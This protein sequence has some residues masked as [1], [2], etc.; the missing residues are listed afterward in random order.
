MNSLCFH[1]SEPLGTSRLVAHINGRDEPVCCAGC[2]AVAELI[3]GAGL[4]QY[5]E[6]RSGRPQ[7]PDETVLADDAWSAYAQAGIAAG[8]VSSQGDLD[9]AT[10]GV[11][12]IRCAAC[13]WL[14]DR[15]VRQ[16]DGVVRVSVNAA[17]ARVHVEWRRDTLNLADIMRSIARAGYRPFPPGDSR[18]VERQQQER[19]ATL[20]R[21][22][23]SGFGMMQVMMF[24]FAAYSAQ[25]RGEAIDPTL[26]EFFRMVSM[27]VAAPVMCYA[28]LPIFANAWRALV[29]R[30]LGMDVPVALALLLAFGASVW[31]TFHGNT[32]EVYF[33]S[34]TMFIFFVTLGR[35]IQMSVRHR[36]TS[37]TDALA[38]QMPAIAHRLEND[39][40]FDVP[41]ATL[42]PGDAVLVRRGEVLPA[43]GELLDAHAQVDESLLTGESAAVHRQQ[44]QLLSGGSVNV[45][46]PLRMAVTTLAHAST[47]A[48]VV[49]LMQRAQAQRPRITAAADAASVRFLWAVVSAAAITALTW[50]FVNPARAFDAT[51]AVLVVACPCAFAIAIPAAV[52]AAI[53]NLARRGVLVTHPDALERL[54]DV[55]RAVFDKTGTLTRGQVRLT[56]YIAAQRADPAQ[57]LAVAAALEAASEHPIA[58][59]IGRAGTAVATEVVTV[60]GAGIEGTV[61]GRRYRIGTP[62]FVAAWHREGA[63]TLAP[64]C[65]GA[66]LVTLGD[67]TRVLMQFELADELREHV[68][69]AIGA[70]RRQG[71]L[72]SI[73]SGDRRSSVDAVA[74]ACGITRR[75]AACS[76]QHKLAHL[77][78]L[79]QQGH[80]VLMLGDGVNDA[81]VLAA[82]DV[83]IAMGRGT[84]LAHASADMILTAEDLN[85]VPH[86]IAVARRMRRIARQNLCWAAAWNFGSLPLAAL[87]AIPPWVAALG[88]SL[89]SI[90]VV[91][92]ATRLLPRESD[93][94]RRADAT[95]WASLSPSMAGGVSS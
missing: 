27:L 40:A 59:A 7:R 58:R 89:S 33:D 25:I 78:S 6:V 90:L 56:R 36:T 49:S 17:T 64:P 77:Q 22:A 2:R 53:A 28:G 94:K 16:C 51:L 87:G 13:A 68:P 41:V 12:G 84:A 11:D 8:I 60:A 35:F 82:A 1:C 29:S 83:S 73:L 46:S 37:I 50:W 4:E 9:R 79:Q 32:G 63:A 18:V 62:Q 85:V 39:A 21:L 55:D 38:R 81:P 14:I 86:A 57:C 43:D 74:D 10:L 66:T 71:V 31:N 80:R 92:N 45:G 75:F 54:A 3:A 30:T 48:H 44:G 93:D 23:V 19:R 72:A 70:L 5:Y 95:R 67:A 24:A 20:R 65:T 26:L 61:Q 15:M 47:L 76:P 69:D 52:S 88:M 34:V 91:M 42:R